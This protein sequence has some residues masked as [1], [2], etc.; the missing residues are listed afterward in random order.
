[1]HG[2]YDRHAL[3]TY[4]YVSSAFYI[5]YAGGSHAV[6]DYARDTIGAIGNTKLEDFQFGVAYQATVP[7]EEA[8][9]YVPNLFLPALTRHW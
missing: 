6:G 5:E 4:S 8:Q 1:M 9:C 3:S 2:T 7:R